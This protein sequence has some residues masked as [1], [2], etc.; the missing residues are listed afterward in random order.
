MNVEPYGE[1]PENVPN[2]HIQGNLLSP[3][4]RQGSHNTRQSQYE[5]PLLRR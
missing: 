2:P 1:Y 4:T 3:R 5:V